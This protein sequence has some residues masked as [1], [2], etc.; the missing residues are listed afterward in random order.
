MSNGGYT[1][2]ECATL[3]CNAPPGSFNANY[4]GTVLYQPLKQMVDGGQGELALPSDYGSIAA[5]YGA[6]VFR[7]TPG[8][9]IIT[10]SFPAVVNQVWPL[11][12]C[13]L[14]ALAKRLEQFKDRKL[15]TQLV[16]GTLDQAQ[17]GMSVGR[18]R[19]NASGPPV[20]WEASVQA[21]GA[22]WNEGFF[23]VVV[24][25]LCANACDSDEAADYDAVQIHASARV[26]NCK[27][28]VGTPS[29]Y[30]WIVPGDVYALKSGAV[31]AKR[32]ASGSK[33]TKRAKSSSSRRT[34]SGKVKRSK[35]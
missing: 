4:G 7:I 9:D 31:G 12:T 5:P 28:K 25:S 23:V 6:K 14:E 26:T 20:D 35:R 1:M 33:K 29:S 27:L 19:Q 22:S 34:S 17:I 16:L 10:F 21:N 2:G 3:I 18:A 30:S 15:A 32:S 8:R 24:F 11:I 13:S